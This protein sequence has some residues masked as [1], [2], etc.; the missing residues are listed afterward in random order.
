MP[1]VTVEVFEVVE[2]IVGVDVVVVEGDS[3]VTDSYGVDIEVVNDDVIVVEAAFEVLGVV[4][5]VVEIDGV[6]VEDDS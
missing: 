6:V 3:E 4:E 5:I 2:I 1:D